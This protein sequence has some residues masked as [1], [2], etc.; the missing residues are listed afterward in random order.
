MTRDNDSLL[1]SLP[2]ISSS[3]QLLH[4]AK[5]CITVHNARQSTASTTMQKMHHQK[6]PLLHPQPPTKL[7]LPKAPS[8]LFDR[9]FNHRRDKI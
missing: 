3:P 5:A 2:P 4:F 8:S 1:I 7:S 9:D 6:A